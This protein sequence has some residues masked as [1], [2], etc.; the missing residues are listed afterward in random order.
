MNP[1]INVHILGTK[2]HRSEDE[3]ILILRRILRIADYIA[4]FR[5]RQTAYTNDNFDYILKNNQNLYLLAA[6]K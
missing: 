3:V 5:I 2:F 6:I 1:L 4:Y